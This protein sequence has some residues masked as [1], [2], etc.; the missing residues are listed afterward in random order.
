MSG[1]RRGDRN[2]K[3]FHKIIKG[4]QHKSRIIEVCGENGVRY[5]REH[6]AG[7]FLEHFQKF[8][9]R[10]DDV[11]EFQRDTVEFTNKLSNEEAELLVRDVTEK[12]IKEAMYDIDDSKAP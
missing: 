6:V 3:F 5:E 1:L 10:K 8:L 9:G 7:P 11:V 2:T 4:R 12:E